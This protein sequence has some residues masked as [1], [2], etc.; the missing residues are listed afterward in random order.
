MNIEGQDK[1]A[2]I[3]TGAGRC[4]MNEEH[5]QTLGSLPL[6][7]ADVGFWLRIASGALMPGM[8]FLTCNM[9]I[10]EETYKQQFIVCKQ[11]TPR[12]ILGRDFLSRNQLGITWGPEG[13]LQ[14][15]DN[16]D[17]PMQT[18]EEVITPAVTLAAKTVVPSRSL[19]LV[20]VLTTLPTCES[21]TRFDFTPIQANPHLG[22]NCIM[23]PLDY[24]SIKGGPQRGLQALINLG[25]QDVKLQEGIVLRHN[26]KKL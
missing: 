20:A 22:P 18:A 17:I 14:L 23:L 7:P 26:L 1:V 13:V 16:Q 25:Q 24:A 3:D 12:I 19:I 8:G 15:R 5:Y 2:L 10:G 6:E 21:K 11:L 4:C 9:Q